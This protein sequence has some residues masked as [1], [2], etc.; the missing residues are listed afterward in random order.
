MFP[1]IHSPADTWNLVR[2]IY[3]RFCLPKLYDYK[4][5]AWGSLLFVLLLLL[6]LYLFEIESHYTALDSLELTKAA[7]PYIP[8]NQPL[9][10]KGSKTWA[11]MPD[12]I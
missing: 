7:W 6:L 11:T 10:L 2:V 9:H 1:E 12:Q 4:S 5:E 8:R 3:F